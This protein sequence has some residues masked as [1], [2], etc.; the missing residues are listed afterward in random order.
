MARGASD[1][2]QLRL[3]GFFE[4]AEEPGHDPGSR[5]IDQPLRAWLNRAIKES[6][7]PRVLIAAEMTELLFGDDDEQAVTRAQLDSWTGASRTEWRF[8]LA[9]LPAFIQATSAYWLMDK[10]ARQSGCRALVGEDALYAELGRLDSV[11]RDATARAKDI[12]KR[13]P[14]RGQR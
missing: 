4:I 6:G 11:S 13:L 9:Y 1:P 7:K 3:D 12:R 2:R 14:K 10:I 8:P 5:N